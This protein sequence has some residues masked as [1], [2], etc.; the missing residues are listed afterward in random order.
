MLDGC[1]KRKIDEGSKTDLR[2]FDTACGTPLKYI[3]FLALFF[4]PAVD[5]GTNFKERGC[6]TEDNIDLNREEGFLNLQ[7]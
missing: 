1:E 7:C 2:A 6:C 5:I 4:G 3:L